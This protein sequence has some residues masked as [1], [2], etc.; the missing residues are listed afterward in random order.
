M[1][2]TSVSNVNSLPALPSSP[3]T[4]WRKTSRMRETTAS[5]TRPRIRTTARAITANVSFMPRHRWVTNALYDLPFGRGKQI[6]A[7]W[8]RILDGVA[9]GWTVS[10][11]LLEQSGQFLNVQYS[12]DDILH[13][14]VRS[15]R[16]DCVAGVSF[17]PADQS[18][19]QFLNRA[20]FALPAAGTFGD[21]E[22]NAVNGPGINSVNL[23]VQKVL[24]ALRTR[25]ASAH[26]PGARRIQPSRS[27]TIRTP[28]LPVAA[29]DD[30][31]CQWLP[32]LVGREWFTRHP[33]R[34]T[35]R[36]LSGPGPHG[37]GSA[38]RRG[39]RPF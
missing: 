8:N 9:G 4:H 38:H 26:W 23:S 28:P 15:G 10:G 21:C 17:Y 29:S 7:N 19:S 39:P 37:R 16:P 25:H 30:H 18:I 34:G 5:A 13:N 14:R 2:W 11:I 33:D 27:S 6:G 31:Q 32:Q 24:Q 1:R 36:L 20:A 35:H 12:G 22:R 3:S